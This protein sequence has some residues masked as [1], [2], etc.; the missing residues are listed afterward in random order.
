MWMWMPEGY[1]VDLF[2]IKAMA[3]EAMRLMDENPKLSGEQACDIVL[4]RH[5]E[6]WGEP[7]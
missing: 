2:G 7:R 1:E 3:E 4:R 5:Q 6:K